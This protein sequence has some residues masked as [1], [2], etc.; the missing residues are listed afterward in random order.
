MDKI[1]EL[2]N[3]SKNYGNFQAVKDVSFDIEPGKIVGL[4]GPNGSGKT[5]I[6]KTIMGLMSDYGGSVDIVG[7]SPGSEANKYISYL[8]DTAHIPRWLT[9]N[10]SIGFFKDFYEDFS[11]AKATDMLVR[12]QIPLEK[13]LKALSRGMQEK[14]SLSLMMSRRAK[15]Y[16]LDEPIGAVDPASREFIIDTILRNFDEGGSILLST[17]I[18]AD[19][20]PILDRALFLREGELVLDDDVEKIREEKGQSLDGLF[21]EVFKNVY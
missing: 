11:G 14:V 16:I 19:I 20:E 3:F 7:Q 9:V 2:K 15:L 4:L 6:I 17:H 18:I 13:K 10:Q 8:P 1:L 5:T 21:R 12:M